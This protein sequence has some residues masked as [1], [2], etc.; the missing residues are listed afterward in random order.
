M[1]KLCRAIIVLV[2]MLGALALLVSP[3]MAAEKAQ[4]YFDQG[5]VFDDLGQHEKALEAYEQGLAIE[6][7]NALLWGA[8]GRALLIM[9]RYQEAAAVYNRSLQLDPSQKYAREGEQAALEKIDGVSNATPERTTATTTPAAGLP[10]WTAILPI[11]W[12]A[13]A[14]RG[15]R[16]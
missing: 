16:R 11:T 13:I 12:A 2:L 5:I 10:W 9:E 8:K 1:S 7:D 6:P 15:R 3:A 4:D 14:G